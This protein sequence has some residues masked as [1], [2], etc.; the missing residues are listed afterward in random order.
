MKYK[1]LIFDLDGTLLYTLEDLMNSTNYSL[2]KFSYPQRTIKE[3]Q[4]FIG[5]GVAV[6]M[7]RS[8]PE[9]CSEERLNELLSIF[10]EHYLEHMYDTTKAYDG[11][12]EMLINLKKQGYK[13]AIVSNKLDA[14][15]KEL[16][17]LY[18]KDLFDCAI[19]APPNAKK[20]NPYSVMECMKNLNVTA[21][22]CIY[23]GD[24]DVD[25]ETAHNAGLKCIGVSWGFRGREF[26]QEINC[27]YI[28]DNPSEIFELI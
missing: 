18:F 28:I 25:L 11:V 17:K 27:D 4:Y 10:K 20:P 2:S 15:V 6:L 19:G 23:I 22:E 21:D 12:I 9:F 8:A 3:I 1:A 13:T 16:D 5:N 26:L 14:A 7:K 24:T